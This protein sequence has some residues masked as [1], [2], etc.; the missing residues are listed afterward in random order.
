MT[1]RT[2]KTSLIANVTGYVQG[3]EKAAAKTR[4]LGSEAEKL[5][6][7]K[8]AFGELGQAGLAIGALAAAGVAVAVKKFADFDQAIS[9]VRAATQETAGNMGLLREAALEFGESSVFTATES[10]NAIEELG[11]AGVATA[12]ILGGAL[13]GSLDLASAGQLGIARAAEIAAITLKQFQL[14]GSDA[15]RV[16]DVLAAAAGKSL[17]SVDDLANGLKFVGPVA[18][19]MGV[20]LEETAG[21]LALFAEQGIIGEQAGTSLRGMLSSLTSPSKLAKAEI[22]ALGITLYDSQGAF[23]GIENAA[24]QLQGAYAGMTDQQRDF[25]LGVLF[26][27]E[28]ITSARVLYQAG[29]EGVAEWSAAVDD[30]GF[31]AEVARDRLDNLKGDVEQLGGAF[32][33]ALIGSGS[34]A[35]DVLRFMTQAATDAV[36]AFNNLDPAAQRASLGIGAVVAGAGLTVGAIFT[37]IPKIAE[38]NAALATMGPRAQFAGKMAAG[39]AKGM[40]AIAAAGVAI[41][42]LDKMANAANGAALS[43]EE[44]SSALLDGELDAAFEDVGRGASDFNG[45]LELLLSNDWDKAFNRFMSDSVLATMGLTDAVTDSR[46]AFDSV[47]TSLAGL[48]SSGSGERAAELFDELAVKAAEQGV[49]TDELLDLLPQ[50]RDALAGVSN[51]QKLAAESTDGTTASVEGMESAAAEAEQAVADLSDTIRN[52]G[53]AQLD[54]N[55]AQRGFEQAVDD[56][57]QALIDNGA[58]IDLNTE[59]GRNNQAAID[60]IASSTNEYA[61]ALYDQNGSLGEASAALAA[62]REKYIAASVGAGIAREQAELY[63]DAL[64]ATPDSITTQAIL[65]GVQQAETELL[66]FIT[67][68]NGRRISI[69]VGTRLQAGDRIANANGNM[70][71]YAN[72]GFAPGIF[73]GGTPLYKFAEPETRWEAF[74]SGKPGEEQRN[75]GIWAEAGRRLGATSGGGGQV[76]VTVSSKGGI[77]LLK[78]VDVQV[79]QG[80]RARGE[81]G[82]MTIEN[83]KKAF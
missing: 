64:F 42:V 34:G 50:Y 82:R 24:G 81:S 7:K 38:F 4:E 51:E 33:T 31:A 26:G 37:A 25:S 72:G 83:G 9:N 47:G 46:A 53:S 67:R 5:A 21:V 75:L 45:A 10:A 16:A 69:G 60:D 3:M 74:I 12:D 52:F 11:K 62:G 13:K 15:G 79:D 77:D 40:V 20:S 63:A 43:V 68:S 1:E 22:E 73:S 6:Q 39:L 23:L 28:Q 36:S 2:V 29:A 76:N 18:N 27:N 70:H 80:V 65:T 35:N 58:T 54:V 48:V 56:A 71:S 44:V 19:A 14:E 55:S 78:Y 32:E 57:T 59:Q 8:E 41:A 61:A 49:S 66:N 17:G 30:S